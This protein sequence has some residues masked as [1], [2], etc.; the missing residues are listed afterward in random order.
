MIFGPISCTAIAISVVSKDFSLKL[1][2]FRIIVNQNLLLFIMKKSCAVI[3]SGIA[4]LAAAIRIASKGYSV[5]VYETNNYAGGKMRELRKDGYR[6]DMGPSVFML[7][8]LIDELFELCHKNPRDYYSYNPL[9]ISFKYFFEDG[10]VINAYTDVEKFGEEI[11]LKTIDSKKTF[12]NYRK[13]IETKYK[14]TNSVFIENSLHVFRNFLNWKTIY[15]LLNFHKIDAFKS[16]NKGNRSF[17]K[18]PRLVQLL[19][20]FATYIG[21]NPFAAPATLNVIQHLEINLGTYLPEKGMYSIVT[22]LVKLATDMGVKF[23]YTTTVEEIITGPSAIGGG[24]KKV[25]GI[26]TKNTALIPYDRVISN[27]DIYYT[28]NKLLPQESAPKRILEQPKSSSVIGFFWGVNKKHEGLGIH[29]M[30]FS[31]DDEGEYKAIFDNKTVSDDPSIYIS[32]SSKKIIA[33]APKD[34]ENWFLFVTVPNDQGQN[35]DELVFRTRKNI[36]EKVNRMLKTD[37][38]K[39]IQFEELLTPPMIKENY[40]SPFGAVYGNS[41]DD[42][43]ASFFRHSNFSKNISGLYFVGGSVHPGAGIPMC[44]NSAKIMDKVFS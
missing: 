41:S 7:P 5:D 24:K 16:M 26:K 30:L 31:N 43:F 38:E 12:D 6:F 2:K 1:L 34:C 23:H 8:E 37:I 27:M 35:W 11:A 25:I 4:G 3:G 22:A 28:F 32:I 42:K 10:C 17:F 36:F 19:N 39:H 29:N 44:L 33:D 20:N 40:S 18:D 21:A 14:I 9:D 13:D 15:G